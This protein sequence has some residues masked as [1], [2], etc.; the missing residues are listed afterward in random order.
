MDLKNHSYTGN[1]CHETFYEIQIIH[2]LV[3]PTFI[4][5]T[6]IM[7]YFLLLGIGL[8]LDLQLWEYFRTSSTSI[9]FPKWHETGIGSMLKWA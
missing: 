1:S 2:A 6:I 7:L 4:V 9:D 3:L 5:L 8:P